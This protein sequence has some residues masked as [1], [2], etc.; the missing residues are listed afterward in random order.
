MRAVMALLLMVFAFMAGTGPVDARRV[1]LVIGINDYAE[2]PSLQKAVGDAQAM[3][4]T[5][6]ELGFEV[7]QVLNADRRGLNI[8]IS[9]FTA[10][11]GPLSKIDLLI[12]TC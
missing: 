4:A 12:W 8:A 5:L 9:Q 3:S 11:L 1:A 10:A 2:V 7:T 6:R